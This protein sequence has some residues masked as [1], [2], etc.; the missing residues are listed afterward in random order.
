MVGSDFID[1]YRT[2]LYSNFQQVHTQAGDRMDIEGGSGNITFKGIPLTWNPM[3]SVLDTED[4]PAEEWEKRCYFLNMNYIRLRPIEGHDM[5]AR[6]PPRPYD[7]YEYYWGLTW[8]GQ[9]TLSRANA[10][11]RIDIA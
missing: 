1:A 10:H 2:Q 6:K 4:S 3:F 8:K 9:E 7:R 11:A 5:I